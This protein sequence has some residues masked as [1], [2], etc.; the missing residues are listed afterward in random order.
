MGFR[1]T[2]ALAA[3]T[4][5]ACGEDFT[6]TEQPLAGSVGGTAWAFVEGDTNDFLS[7]GDTYFASL[8]A[9]DFEQC[10]FG[11]PSGANSVILNLPK[12]TGEWELSLSRNMTFVVQTNEGVDNLIGIDGVIRVDSITADTITGGVHAKYDDDNEIDGTF[13]VAICPPSS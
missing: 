10:G 4:L 12:E 8:Y 6:I 3:C 11:S 7:D 1:L 5:F 9:S 13:S 2:I